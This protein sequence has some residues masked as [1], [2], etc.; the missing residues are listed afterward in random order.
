MFVTPLGI[1][2]NANV[3]NTIEL[4]IWI[5][6][7]VLGRLLHADSG[8]IGEVTA[9]DFDF[10]V[11]GVSLALVVALHQVALLVN[12]FVLLHHQSQPGRP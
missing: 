7:I 11:D 6:A 2:L 8:A 4:G 3:V 10:C 12:R 9:G 1:N 5:N